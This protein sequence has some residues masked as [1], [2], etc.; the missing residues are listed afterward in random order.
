MP[1]EERSAEAARAGGA[2]ISDFWFAQIE[3]RLSRLES[4][5]E[6][7]ERHL[8]MLIYAAGAVLLIEVLRALAEI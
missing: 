1:G 8:W 6:R 4:M 3:L 2:R 5:V 7:L